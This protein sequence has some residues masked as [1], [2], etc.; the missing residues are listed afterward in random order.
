MIAMKPI[1]HTVSERILLHLLDYLSYTTEIEVPL[2]ATQEGISKGICIHRKHIPRSL[3]QLID[4]EFITEKKSH[5]P[6]KK[7][8]IKSYFL[9]ES[10][11][12][13]AIRIKNT[14]VDESIIIKNQGAEKILTVSEAFEYLKKQ[15]SYACIISQVTRNGYFN[16]QE[17]NHKESE[18]PNGSTPLD[19]EQIYKKVLMEAWKDGILTIDERNILKRLRESLQISENTHY[20]I[21]RSILQSDQIDSS[22]LYRQVYDLILTEVL[23]D[24]KISKDE[25]AILKKLKKHF[26]ISEQ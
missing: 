7:Q 19:V 8:M 13:A 15:Y 22:Q 16:E 18:N 17:I 2:E 12:T 20:R 14:I 11:R 25:E 21:Q 1:H 5:I 3:K 23:K 9:T 10:G 24:N 6:G 26:N 4:Q